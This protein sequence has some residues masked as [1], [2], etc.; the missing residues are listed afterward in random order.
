MSVPSAM[1]PRYLP[2]ASHPGGFL[3]PPLTEPALS[4][5]GV[6][7]QLDPAYSCGRD[8]AW[9]FFSFSNFSCLSNAVVLKV[10]EAVVSTTLSVKDHRKDVV[11][12]L[13][14]PSQ[15]EL[16][17]R[18]TVPGRARACARTARRWRWESPHF[19]SNSRVPETI[20]RICNEFPFEFGF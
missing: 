17:P 12:L 9:Y 8:P 19:F 15:S 4:L 7:G 16:P 5:E 3:T 14:L 13:A 1:F 11:S 20:A 2:G 10:R 18:A 6:I